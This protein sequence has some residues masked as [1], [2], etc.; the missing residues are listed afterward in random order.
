[1]P[2]SPVLITFLGWKEKHTM[3][4]IG[5]PIF[6]HCP[7]IEISLPIAQA[8]SSTTRRSCLRAIAITDVMSHGMPIWCTT[9]IARVRG[10]I[11]A[12]M[13]AGSML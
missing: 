12:S 13:A 10:V 8:A 4:P 9:R 2:P 6:C 5:R 11:A 3:S 7:L 1:M